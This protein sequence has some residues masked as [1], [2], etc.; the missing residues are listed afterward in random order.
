VFLFL[1]KKIMDDEVANQLRQIREQRLK[2]KNDENWEEL[3]ASAT[4][5]VVMFV[6]L[7]ANMLG[8]KLFTILGK[9][10]FNVEVLA[11]DYG[12]RE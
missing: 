10:L 7:L 3:V 9:K 1:K 5:A 8:Y 6:P 4:K 11:H 12:L 2:K